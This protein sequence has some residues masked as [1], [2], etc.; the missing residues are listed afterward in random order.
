MILHILPR[1]SIFI[2]IISTQRRRKALA[3]EVGGRNRSFEVLSFKTCFPLVSTRQ[4]TVRLESKGM[5]KNL[6]AT[7][8]KGKE[9]PAY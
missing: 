2:Y 1:K 9:W 6:E 4:N 3:G 8:N 5:E 7:S